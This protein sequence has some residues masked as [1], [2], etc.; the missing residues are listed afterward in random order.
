MLFFIKFIRFS[1]VKPKCSYNFL[2]GPLAPNEHIPKKFLFG[3]YFSHPFITPASMPNR[4][5][6]PNIFFDIQCFVL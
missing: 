6:F 5:L 1:E 2:Y 3:M 4:G